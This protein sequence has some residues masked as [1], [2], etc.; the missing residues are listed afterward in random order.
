MRGSRG[1][2]L[3]RGCVM[4]AGGM[5]GQKGKTGRGGFP[6]GGGDETVGSGR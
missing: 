4:P 6:L 2:F 5:S 3:Y 1:S